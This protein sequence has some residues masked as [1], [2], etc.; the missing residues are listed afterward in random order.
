MLKGD[1]V[2]K[3]AGDFGGLETGGKKGKDPTRNGEKHPESVGV[4]ALKGNDNVRKV[5]GKN[6]RLRDR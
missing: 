2:G 3:L 4:G 5:H 1:A 6:K